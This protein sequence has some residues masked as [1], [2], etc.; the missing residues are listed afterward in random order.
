MRV[1]LASHS[2]EPSGAELAMLDVAQAFEG[3]GLTSLVLFLGDGPLVGEA[4]N[5]GLEVAVCPLG[6]HASRLRR[7]RAG[8]G[9]IRV[10][11]QIVLAIVRL[12]RVL[13]E[14]SV[15]VLE[16]NSLKAHLV[17][18]FACS[19][20]RT[21]CVWRLRDIVAP[22]HLSSVEAASIRRI[23]RRADLVVAVSSAAARSVDHPRALVEPSAITVERFQ[24]APALPSSLPTPLRIACISR[25]APWKGQDVVIQAAASL[26]A[27]LDIELL[28]AGDALF[29]ETH[30]REQLQKGA[31]ANV[32]FL[33]HVHDVAPVLAMCHVVAHT[34][35]MPEPFGKV[36]VEAMAAG[37]I[38]I[39]PAEGGPDEILR[40][41]FGRWLLPTS[42]A[43]SLAAKVSEIAADWAGFTS[44]AERAREAAW[45]Y[46]VGLSTVRLAAAYTD[47]IGSK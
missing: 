7:R 18:A 30:Y 13:R 39:A 45:T 20:S 10:L 9:L 43:T 2:A 31:P 46:D 32:R 36:V 8:I 44:D 41:D 4:R 42:D 47:L 11:P 25:L 34:P 37:R 12:R 29:G 19:F 26:A 24:G 40:K 6:G 14:Q 22:P 5:R 1:A 38:V 23:A 3:L 33:G 28:I 35:Q 21:L 17:G 16:T 27:Q 15:D